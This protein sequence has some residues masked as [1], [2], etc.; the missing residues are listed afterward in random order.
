MEQFTLTVGALLRERLENYK[1]DAVVFEYGVVESVGDGVV[2]LSGLSHCRYG[3]L[4]AFKG[5]VFAM[6]MELSENRV[7]AVLLNGENDLYAGEYA[8]STGRV[9]EVPVGTEL[10]GRVVDPLGMPLDGKPITSTKLR[11]IE[12]PAPRIIE[13]GPVSKP[14]ET[15]LLAIDSMIP[16]GRGQR[17]LIIGDRQTGKTTIAVD[18]I[19]NQKNKNVRC[20][21]VAIGQKASTVAQIRD[22][23][24]A[25]GA[26]AYT[27]IVAATSSDCAAMQYIAPYAGCAIAEQF[28]YDGGDALIIYDDLS[29]HAVAYRAMSLLLRR[30]PGREAYPGDVFYLHSRLLERAACLC[31]ELGG[32]TLTALPIVETMAND[33]SAYIPTNVIS[34][35]DG[36]IYLETELFHAGVRPAVNIGLSVSRVGRAAQR[37]AMRDVSGKLRLSLAQYRELQI[38][39]QFGSDVD[40]E[41]KKLLDY[42][43]RLTETLKQ[44]QNSPYPL[45]EQVVLLLS[46]SS[47]NLDSI[48]VHDSR[49][50]ERELLRFMRKHCTRQMDQIDS[51]GTLPDERKAYLLRAIGRFHWAYG[52]MHGQVEQ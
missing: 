51:D 39:A 50:F 29:K 23:L 4:I 25:A 33:I 31:G 37:A 3:E 38:F 43:D 9:V 27:T 8:R 11:P 5:D 49:A 40:V 19:L 2:Q 12:G 32:G 47:G 24:T 45:S 46:V 14:L 36:Q 10:L 35:T 18:T 15:G 13:R 30:P 21:Y 20:V 26:M 6:A 16:V 22:A 41:T 52:R 42:G 17:E 48:P 34:I 44:P 28:M 1:D 7:G